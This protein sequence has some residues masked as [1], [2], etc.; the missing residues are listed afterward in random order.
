[1]TEPQQP[2]PGSANTD[3]SEEITQ[4]VSSPAAPSQPATGSLPVQPDPQAPAQFGQ[5]QYPGAQYPAGAVQPGQ[6]YPAGGQFGQPQPAQSYGQPGQQFAQ[7]AQAYGQQAQQFGQAA[8]YGQPFP[9]AVPGAKKS[10]GL[11][12][13]LFSVLGVVVLG[14][15]VLFTAFV[16][17]GW[18]P[19]KLTQSGAE[20]GVRQIL[21]T[22]YQVK[23]V[24]NVSCPAATPVKKGSTFNC[25][26]NIDGR[27]QTVPI[28]FL[29][30]KGGFEVGAPHD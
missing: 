6:Q 13:A 7:P 14:A 19:K 16:A 20:R 27:R 22:D 12:V 1:M 29:D 5:P 4:V 26:V 17:P 11:K 2:T 21:S 18:A 3:P 30:N 25:T 28:T 24:A 23:D 8:P 9:G 10:N 15:I